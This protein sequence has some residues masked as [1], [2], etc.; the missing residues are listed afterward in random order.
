MQRGC[1]PL[2]CAGATQQH[3][4]DQREDRREAI[5]WEACLEARFTSLF[6]SLPPT[7]GGSVPGLKSNKSFDSLPPFSGDAG[8]SFRQWHEK[9]CVQQY[10]R[11]AA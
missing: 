2:R 5:E 3:R 10:C 8:Q 9:F 11:H 6:Q 1:A 7:S 4:E